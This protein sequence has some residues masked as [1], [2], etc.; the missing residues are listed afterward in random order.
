MELSSDEI[1][2]CEW[3]SYQDTYFNNQLKE[4]AAVSQQILEGG[5][6]ILIMAAWNSFN[7]A[8]LP[9]GLFN[10]NS[11]IPN[12]PGGL[13]LWQRKRQAI[14]LPRLRCVIRSYRDP[15]VIKPQVHVATCRESRFCLLLS[16]SKFH[17]LPLYRY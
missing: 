8:D 1:S 4:R 6:L 7:A 12:S 10:A 5:W 14:P 11:R 16:L 2:S 13:G 17:A 3:L 9:A 15:V